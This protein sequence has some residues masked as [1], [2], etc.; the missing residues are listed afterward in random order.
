M[1]VDL[2]DPEQKPSKSLMKKMAELEIDDPKTVQELIKF[3]SYLRF[4]KKV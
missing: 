3:Y 2:T 1:D 4:W